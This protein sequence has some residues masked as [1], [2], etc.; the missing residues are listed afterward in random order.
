MSKMRRRAGGKTSIPCRYQS[1]RGISLSYNEQS[2]LDTNTSRAHIFVTNQ[3]P[4]WAMH[5]I[6]A[7]DPLH[8]GAHAA[9]RQD[10]GPEWTSRVFH[11]G[12]VRTRQVQVRRSH[13]TRVNET[14][15]A[16]AAP[17]ARAL[18]IKTPV[19]SDL[20]TLRRYNDFITTLNVFRKCY[21][22]Q[23]TT[24]AN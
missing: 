24:T 17:A 9:L 19:S 13:A 5:A 15:P 23:L 1:L 4:R 20:R 8:A 7:C 11:S 2:R 14:H 6:S 10:G 21:V 3:S 12:R 22:L 16:R 18:R